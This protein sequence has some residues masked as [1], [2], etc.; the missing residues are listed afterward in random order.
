MTRHRTLAL[1]ALFAVLAG[2][3][4][5]AADEPSPEERREQQV[6]ERFQGVLDKNPRRGTALDRLY[7]Y[8]V[9]R[10]TLDA[11]IKRYADR[12]KQNANDGV[13]WMVLGLLEAQRG[14]DAAAVTAFRA[15]EQHRPDDPL[16]SHYLGQTLVLVGQPDAAAEAFERAITR[17]PNRADLLDAFQA[18]GRVYQRAQKTEQALAVWGRLE[19][20][21]PDDLR[22]QEQI[23]STLAE[24]GQYDQALPRYEKLAK[25]VPDPYRQATFRME[26]AEL[27]VRL[28]RTPQ[29][30]DDLERLLGTL[31]PDNWLYRDVR[32]KIEEVFL[33]N[34]D[35]AGLAKYYEGWLHKNPDDVEGMTRL[36][37]TLA[38][39]GRMPE[40]RSWLEK[41]VQRAPTRRDLRQAMIDQL[42]YEQKYADALAQYEAMDKADPNNPDTLREWGK[43]LLR[44]TSRPEA[45]RK[46]QAVAVWKRLLDRRPKDPVVAAQVADL[47]RTAGQ[48]DEALALYNR[49][50][51]LA[52]GNAQ[53]REYLGEYLH[54]LKR[55]AEALAAWRP[56]AAGPNRTAK[57][58]ARLAEVFAGFGYKT[59]AIAAL[60][61]ALS[62]EK[63]DFNLV[64]RH[65]E[66]LHDDGQ[67]DAALARLDAAAKLASNAEE[68]ESVLVAQVKIYQATDTLAARTEA[69]QKELAAS[70]DATADRWH[71]LARYREAARQTAGA[72]A[73]ILTA[74]EKDPKSVPILASAARIHE[75]GDNLLAAADIHRRLAAVDRRFRTEYL[76][77]V[78]KLE[79]RLG[80]REQALQA[81]R[82]LLAAAPGNPDHYKFF[83]ELCFQLGQGEEGLESL[84]R[85][86]RANPSD[87]EGLK[88]L[89]S[90]LAERFRPGEA[91]ELL[92]RAFDKSADLDGK[93]GVVAR[94]T[95]LYLQNNQFDKLLERLERERREA[96]KQ[97]EMTICI[98]AAYQAAGDLGTARGQLE[99]LLS[100]NARDTQLLAQ[101]SQLADSEGDVPLAVKY[102]RQLEKA[103]PNNRDHRLRLAQLLAR[104]G[105][106]EEAAS[107][108]VDLVTTETEPHRTHQAIDAL[109]NQE[110]PETALAVLSKLLAQKPGDWEL[111]YR[112][113][114]ALAA[115]DKREEAAR[116][117]RAVL[118]LKVPDDEPSAA[119]KF[120]KRQ[121]SGRQAGT[122]PRSTPQQDEDRHPL[123]TRLQGAY[124]IRYATGLDPRNW[125]GGTNYRS[126]APRD[127]GQCRMAAL[128][129]LLAFAT[130]DNRQ[131]AFVASRKP[132]DHAGADSRARWDWLYLQAVR[133]K[134]SE[135]WEAAKALAATPDPAGQWVY[136]NYLGGRLVS[137]NRRGRRAGGDRADTGPP[138]PPA[139]LEQVLTAYRRL[140]Q[141]KPEW[142]TQQ[143]VT[144]VLTELKRAGRKDEEATVYREA[145]TAAQ[146][147]AA[148][149]EALR[150][151]AERGDT[152]G[153]L[154][155]F[156]RIAKLPPAS[157]TAQSIV[158]TTPESLARLMAKRAEAKGHAD[159]I[160]IF[161]AYLVVHRK[162]R[163]AAPPHAPPAS[164]A[165][166]VSYLMLMPGGYYRRHTVDWPPAN[167]YYDAGSIQLLR[168]A[169]EAYQHDD[170]VSDLVTLVAKRRDEAPP[171]ER[172][173][174][175]LGLAY[176]HWWQQER[177]SA[178]AEFIAAV[179]LAPQDVNLRFDL[180]DLRE[181]SN[182][183]DDALAVLDAITPTDH[184]TMMRR[185]EAALRLA[186]RTG[187]VGRAREA[188]DRL[189][190]LRLDAEKQVRLAAH[191]HRLG[192][193][194]AAEAVLARA[195]RQAGNR[196]GAMVSLMHQYQGQNQPDA[197]VQIARQLLRKGP[198]LNFTPYRYSNDESD[199]RAEAIQVLARSGQLAELIER[200]EA[201]L[202]ASPRSLPL[203][204]ALIDYYKAAGDKDKLKA[205]ALRMAAL[206]P[207]DAKLHYQ[208]AQQFSETGD[209]ADAA[210]QYAA[211]LRKEPGLFAYQYWEILQTFGQAQKSKDLVALFD[212]IDL[213][214]LGGNYYAFLSVIQPL[215]S[216]RETRDQGLRLFRK[217]WAAFPEE[218]PQMLGYVS[219]DELWRLPELYDYAREAVIPKGD[220]LADPWLGCEEGISYGGDG[221]VTG[222]YNRVADVARRQNRLGPLTREVDAALAK[223]PDWAAGRALRAVLDAHQGRFDAARSAFA[224]LVEDTRTPMPPLARFVFGQELEDYAAL[225]DVVVKGYEGAVDQLLKGEDNDLSYSPVRRLIKLY[226]QDGRKADARAL[227]LRCLR[228]H[229]EEYDAGYS[230]YRRLS[231][232][233]AVA[234]LLAETGF[235]VDAARTYAGLLEDTETL[236]AAARYYGENRVRPQIDAGLRQTLKRLKPETLPPAVR[237]LLQPKADAK[238]GPVLDLLLIQPDG[239]LSTAAIQSVLALALK[240]T[241]QVPE[242]RAEAVARLAELA[243]QQ[244]KDSSVLTAA[245]LAALAEDRPERIA[246]AAERLWAAAEAQ[247]LEALP[248][249]VRANSRQRAAALPQVGLWLAARE[250]LKRDPL[251][252]VGVKLGERAL[253]AARRQL[254]P[255]FALAV[256][257]EWGQIEFDR[258]DRTGAEQRW[259]QMLELVLP[260][261][262]PP[263]R[264]AA[265]ATMVPVVTQTQFGRTIQI[266]QL[267]A[268]RN[269]PALSQRAVRDALR[270]G[271]PVPDPTPSDGGSSNSPV[272]S[273]DDGDSS[274]LQVETELAGLI[275]RWRRS[276]VGPA[277]VY[278]TL[279]AVV[280]PDARPTEAF[281]YPRSFA[282][283]TPEPARSVG[284]LLADAA[285]RC[286]KLDDLRRRAESR[287]D[288]PLGELTAH[289]LLGQVA[290]TAG[291]AGR[292]AAELDWFTQRLAKDTL[293]T[294]AELACHVALPALE[295][296]ESESAALALLDR[297]AKNLG[298]N[299]N[300]TRSSALRLH[301]ARHQFRRGR[302]DEGRRLLKEVTAGAVKDVL[303][304]NG[305]GVAQPM[306]GAVREYV[307]AGL[308]PEALELVG[309]AADL[310]THVRN[311]LGYEALPD[312]AVGLYRLLMARPAA[313]RH[314]ILKAWTLPTAGRKSVRLFGAMVPTDAPPPVFGD[315]HVPSDGVVHTAVLLIDAAREAGK[316]DELAAEV[317]TLADAKVENARTLSLL[318]Q[319]VRGPASAVNPVLAEHLKD[320]RHRVASPPKQPAAARY[321]YPGMEENANQEAV[322]WADVLVCRACLADPA[323]APLGEAMADQLL[324]QSKR[325]QNWGYMTFLRA[326]VASSRVA[327]DPTAARDTVR[328]RDPGLALWHPAGTRNATTPQDARPPV[329]WVAQEGHLAHVVG[330]GDDFLLFDHPLAGKFTF[331]VEAY[332]GPFAEG[333]VGYGGLMF[334]PNVG[335]NPPTVSPVGRH[336][337]VNRPATGMRPEAFNTLTVEVEPGKVR[338]LVNGRLFYED[339][340][341]GPTSP[342]LALFA[343]HERHTV[344]RNPR[345]TGSPTI[346]REVR[347]LHSDRLEGWTGTLSGDTLPPRLRLREPNADE[348]DEQ[349]AQNYAR[350]HF[351]PMTPP[352]YDWKA[353]DGELVGRRLDDAGVKGPIPSHLGY[354]RPL[355]AGDVLRYEFFHQ[356]G[357]VEVHPCLGRVVF[358]LQRDG[359][360]LR[361]LTEGGEDDWTGLPP[362]NAREVPEHRRGPKVLPLKAGDWNTLTVKMGANATTLELNDVTVYECPLATADSRAFGLYHD[363]A[364]T[365]ARVRNAVLTGNWSE[366]LP[367]TAAGDL[368]ARAGEP[369]LSGSARRAL[370]GEAFFGR[371]ASAMLAKAHTLTPAER[372]DFLAGWV[373]P[374]G[375]RTVF[376]LAGDYT[377]ADPA[378]PAPPA[379][380]G[381]MPAGTR[382]HVGGD[383]V[384]PAQE[385]VNIARELGKLDELAARAEAIADAADRRGKLALLALIR[386][387]Q[388]RDDGAA[389]ALKSLTES[390]EQLPADTP[391]WQRWPELVAAAGVLHRPA[392]VAPA[393]ALL[394]AEANHLVAARSAKVKFDGQEEWLYRTRQIRGRA[395]HLALP[396]SARRPFGADPGL[397]WWAPAAD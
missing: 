301:L 392:L 248:P 128:G 255:T 228:A 206:K 337:T 81:G 322:A 143:V 72:T 83:A 378:P 371:N 137:G 207:D 24:E 146:Q 234:Q 63:D 140:K 244:A 25:A 57:N 215:L 44:D 49:A 229:W 56:I 361:W 19:Q 263:K 50:I 321:Y 323:L 65:A 157:R 366:T 142:L 119:E 375:E 299:Q 339:S 357:E 256:L 386:A 324:I 3:S 26:A 379:T 360:R 291:D 70:K 290:L 265:A 314:T 158:R 36:A 282:P 381:P 53:Y 125:Y 71:R 274:G 257:K 376:Q 106:A 307:R 393:T 253:E 374:G 101:L 296:P 92:W 29:A 389:A 380:T 212:E 232:G 331:S 77:N 98:A 171:E 214:R 33:R 186:V 189:F 184:V 165:Q 318:A 293:L 298:T 167:D 220:G 342:W 168:T 41:A 396:E 333:H 295:R 93:L 91:I 182:E 32:R 352:E 243:G 100:E 350:P 42:V 246:E 46:Q 208:L 341:L 367:A 272:S 387:A 332:Q 2:S 141:Q 261:P 238:Q 338:C 235:P 292:V 156:D 121:R 130:R 368:L 13:A 136:L 280:L 90:A 170:L 174:Y 370:V 131:D 195:H 325:V 390:V 252:P 196:T 247:P 111:L 86:V 179:A 309:T 233:Q 52:P 340:D 166:P 47:V 58:L 48:V 148:L 27:K 8:H 114:S 64:L 383:L 347:L 245:F 160:R 373:L 288:Q 82:D 218:R 4:S 193:H 95:E 69:L 180:A 162:E 242:L 37:R 223:H 152:D 355:R 365:T 10:G 305:S 20:L 285:A 273:P 155:V 108:W 300:D 190:G 118:D 302:P 224:A 169:F 388:G 225:R 203:H 279:A 87:P 213:K 172:I 151:A 5:P 217:A 149:Q 76:T 262:V 94:L 61:D 62:L 164:Q 210:D 310:P 173:G 177:E 127:Y 250:C 286:S 197:A 346:P 317:Q 134:Q 311:N 35:Q 221:R 7:G 194:A 14:K 40:S 73:A 115:L 204:Q 241:E 308:L 78:A 316:L 312:V 275:A 395:Q 260:A 129:W 34:D 192:M 79:A 328:L 254:E 382:V 153:A 222:L 139:E 126:W 68:A 369:A 297:A 145:V 271:P 21:F 23:A 185:E 276:G 117:F 364:H 159:L 289:V 384:A 249:G 264:A 391:T 216:Q 354:F 132:R 39:Q 110:K 267:A 88:T 356:P 358:L 362:D 306:Q 313:E 259:G 359:V 16:A 103:A 84:R 1:A 9:E 270:G 120:K 226:D 99:R 55:P 334:E 181:R 287:R 227:A 353:K 175:R 138:L 277:E 329:W 188:A 31:N 96:D 80:R 38:T 67:P 348:P 200:A 394:N 60:A 154:A 133:Q 198:S 344:F 112:E 230:A 6:M 303:R 336:E 320:L 43:L 116:R 45:D 12:T 107:V 327:R 209:F 123:E 30:L 304:N 278:E 283:G 18:L 105:E 315:V 150:L 319:A 251:R 205:V 104:A 15:A 54:S 351:R 122:L 335:N 284:Q 75:S 385:L 201:Q 163:Q 178:V 326:A 191:M 51:E 202:K 372:Y 377:P 113:G 124:E 294:T 269:L 345:L 268:D 281:V 219:D 343:G 240:S 102:Q 397:T 66:L 349:E 144:N 236:E 161:D 109:L 147:P 22:V 363:K 183:P 211:A 89:A 187:N 199:G 231:N 266:A 135:A 85:G 176:M 17:K 258:K 239:D 237:D 97:R 11:L 330:P 59:E 28:K 74:L